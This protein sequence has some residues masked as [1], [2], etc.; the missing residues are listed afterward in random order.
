MKNQLKCSVLSKLLEKSYILWLFSFIASLVIVLLF[1]TSVSPIYGNAGGDSV[2][3]RII[4][5]GWTEGRLPYRDLFDH[6]GPVIFF[7]DAIATLISD[8][9]FGLY[10]LSVIGLSFDI[11]LI[12]KIVSL[13]VKKYQI[14]LCDL[15]F[16]AF[17]LFASQGG[18]LT[19]TWNLPFILL[20]IYLG[21]NYLNSSKPIENH[22]YQYSFIYGISMGII[23][24]TRPNNAIPICGLILTYTILLIKNKKW[25]SLFMN[26][27]FVFLG[28]VLPIIPFIIYFISNE[29]LEE[30]IYAAF[31]FNFKYAQNA[32]P[33]TIKFFIKFCIMTFYIFTVVIFSILLLKKRIL[34]LNLFIAIIFVT[35]PT[36]VSLMLGGSY[37][38][39]WL[40][41]TISFILASCLLFIFINNFNQLNIINLSKTKKTIV[42]IF[43]FSGSLFYPFYG[44]AFAVARPLVTCVEKIFS[45]DIKRDGI[46]RVDKNNGVPSVV[47]SIEILNLISEEDRDNVFVYNAHSFY[48]DNKLDIMPYPKCKYFCLQPWHGK[49]DENIPIE[50]NRMMDTEPPKY[51]VTQ[52]DKKDMEVGFAAKLFNNYNLLFTNSEYRLY[53][54]K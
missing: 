9:R 19:E 46:Y 31:T 26:A 29:I 48:S 21:F 39:Y 49:F 13:F 16:I 34:K 12:H 47:P 11:Y 20:C 24:M 10:L 36:S 1:Q 35:V 3:F 2:I 22:P 18:N 40:I 51:I 8:S 42:L 6:K 28:F 52:L 54:Y 37:P 15:T 41:D 27:L 17:Y 23:F 30:F 32:K 38:H 4:G 14:F 53:I 50:I 33:K 45:I 7:I 25:K 44:A 5:K 43:F